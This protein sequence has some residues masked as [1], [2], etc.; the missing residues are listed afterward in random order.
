[1]QGQQLM[2]HHVLEES[3]VVHCNFS[4]DNNNTLPLITVKLNEKSCMGLLDSG[5]CINL[6]FKN[7]VSGLHKMTKQCT[8]KIKTINEETLIVREYVTIPITVGHTQIDVEFFLMDRPFSSNFQMIL[9][10]QF[11]QNNNCIMDFG[12]RHLKLNNDVILW[13]ENNENIVDMIEEQKY[14]QCYAY[15]NQKTIIPPLSQAIVKV[16]IKGH[17]P[18]DMFLAQPRWSI[19]E[20][21]ILVARTVHNSSQKINIPILVLNPTDHS[22]HLNKLTKIVNCEPIISSDSLTDKQVFH[23]DLDSMGECNELDLL[24]DDTFNLEH[25]E[26]GVKEKLI[27]LLEKNKGVFAKTVAELPGC[28]TVLHRIELKEN[29]KV[30]KKRPYRVPYNLREEMNNQINILLEADIIQPS[31]SEFAAPVMLIRKS[32]GEYRF[33]ADFRSLNELIRHDSFPLPIISECIDSL[34]GAKYFSTLDLTSG[35]FQMMLDPRDTHKTAIITNKGLF[36]FK[37]VPFGLSTSANS[38]QRLMEIVLNGLDAQKIGCFVDDIVIASSTIEEHFN[39][40]QLVFDRLLQHNLRLKPSKCHFLK[41]SI[42]YL[43]FEIRD[44]EILPDKKNI[45]VVQNFKIPKTRK[46]VKSFLGM[47]NFY[48]KF[49]PDFSLRSLNLTNLTKE[50]QPFVWTQEAEAEFLDL[51]EA[52]LKEPCLSLP[53]MSRD[54]VLYTDASQES[55]GIVLS[56]FDQNKFPKP[57]S[58]A[59][60]KLKPA[61]RNY[62]ATEREILAIIYAVTYFR[63]YL[64]GRKFI[65]YC[66][67]KALTNMLKIRDSTNKIARWALTL[68][69]YQY[70]IRYL[71]GR[72]NSVADFLSR[73]VE[74]FDVQTNAENQINSTIH[75]AP[76]MALQLDNQPTVLTISSNLI[77]N[78][79]KDQ[80]TDPKCQFIIDK[81]QKHV[82]IQPRKLRFFLENEILMCKQFSAGTNRNEKAKI[83]V[84]I[85]QIAQVLELCHDSEVACHNGIKKTLNRIRTDF[86]WSGMFSHVRN[87][88]KSCH[89]CMQKAAHKP[90]KLAPLERNQITEYPGQKWAIDIVGPFPISESG[91]RYIITYIDYFTRWAEVFPVHDVC[92]QNVASTLLSVISRFGTPKNLVSDKGKNI[93][94]PTMHKLF[95]T[96]G[97]HKMQ[98]TSYYPQSNGVLEAYHKTLLKALSHLVNDAHSNWDT[99]LDYALLAY[100][101]SIH[102]ATGFTPAFLCYGREM[103]LPHQLLDNERPFSYAEHDDYALRLV[104]TLHYAFNKAKK[105]LVKAAETQE[106]YRMKRAVI[107]NIDVGDIVYLFTPFSK[108]GKSRKLSK[109]NKRFVVTRKLS[110]VLYEIA[111]ERLLDHKQLVNVNRLTKATIRDVPGATQRGAIETD[112]QAPGP[113]TTAEGMSEEQISANQPHTYNLRNRTDGRVRN[114]WES[115]ADF[116]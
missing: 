79:K 37:R 7:L 83:V 67:H 44:G 8:I 12:N 36:E 110:P 46:Q 54:F 103:K 76:L 64:F 50:K 47:I 17:I 29:N 2:K 38:F 101:T 4:L 65:I 63:H 3:P 34:Q 31:N 9:G 108:P 26:N 58:F 51:K 15:V 72:C 59:S 111:R 93:I 90:K 70:E 27:S 19:G 81:L 1:M 106:E 20:K 78:I 87:W 107:Q 69:E 68:A 53:D 88:I 84:P 89:E 95:K 97:V 43:G 86:Y 23:V 21:D 30:A 102:S 112:S 28:S 75:N 18:T 24:W 62:S 25:L 10:K 74:Y 96:L 49:V 35:F 99:Q 41:Q 14:V 71:P 42:S 91:N 100:R 104:N 60:R 94:N 105:C 5:A 73:G 11:L 32:S 80:K 33:V 40:L 39:K 45:E 115:G 56:Q 114:P 116:C 13:N 66:D 82:P 6:L 113:S 109:L 48:R 16:N 61:E 52:L 77:N 57:V 22:Y 85:S 92:S 55:L 98:T